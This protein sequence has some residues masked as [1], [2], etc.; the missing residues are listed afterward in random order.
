[1]VPMSFFTIAYTNFY[2][3]FYRQTINKALSLNIRQGLS[4]ELDVL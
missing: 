3:I 1:M 4:A 2:C